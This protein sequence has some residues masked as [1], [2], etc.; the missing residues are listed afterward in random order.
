LSKVNIEGVEC[1]LT[2]AQIKLLD[3]L[4]PENYENFEI[5]GIKFEKY[6]EN[7]LPLSQKAKYQE[8]L[9]DGT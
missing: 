1:E 6:D 5:E 8:F 4:I 2:E 3:V 7:G 9:A